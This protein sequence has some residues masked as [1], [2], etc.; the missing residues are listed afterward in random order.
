GFSL[1]INGKEIGQGFQTDPIKLEH[2]NSADLIENTPEAYEKLLLDVLNGDGTNFTHWDE[3]AQ[4]WRIVDRIRETWDKDQKT[5]PGYSAGTMGPKE[6]Y[7][8]L[9]KEDR[10][11]IW[12]PD[13]WYRQRGLLK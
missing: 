6:A 7:Q 8:L 1:T 11:W 3:V 9:E 10:H 12:E 2:R 4:S 5:P 13:E